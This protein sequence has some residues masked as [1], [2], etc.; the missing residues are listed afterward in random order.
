MNSLRLGSSRCF[1]RD[2]DLAKFGGWIVEND[3]LFD[4]ESKNRSET[5]DGV[6]ESG[7]RD[8]RLGVSSK[9]ACR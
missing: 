1:A 7:R 8:S 4:S 9:G 3:A 6:I 5:I 2:L